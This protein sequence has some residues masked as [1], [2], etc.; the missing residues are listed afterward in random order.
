MRRLLTVILTTLAVF[1]A[2][3]DNSIAIE[4]GTVEP[5]KPYIVAIQT[6]LSDNPFINA[7]ASP[8]CTG[9]LLNSYIVVT[10]AHCIL[11]RAKA[12][13]ADDISVYV[14]DAGSER[15]I[16]G[17][18]SINYRNNHSV[19][20]VKILDTYNLT[21]SAS[22]QVQTDD[23]AFLTLNNPIKTE[24]PFEFAT[25]DAYKK[26]RESHSAINI[27]GFGY[28]G[29][30]GGVSMF[31]TK[32]HSAKAT[33][34]TIGTDGQIHNPFLNMEIANS[35]KSLICV[36]D[37]GGPVFTTKDGKLYLLGVNI[38]VPT[39]TEK[40]LCGFFNSLNNG[41]TSYF[42]NINP[43]L[44]IYKQVLSEVIANPIPSAQP[45][46]SPGYFALPKQNVETPTKTVLTKKTIT[47]LKG[48]TTK[49]IT[50]I[51]VKCPTGYKQK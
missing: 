22:R 26:I 2:A 6:S 35:A 13:I 10:A 17:G 49:K 18:W 43:Y 14:P 29:Q 1:I 46:N 25:D 12:T 27:Y 47:C 42:L 31:S 5:Y 8:T 38:G 37:S 48:K 15:N 9:T 11:N 24:T 20:K 33:I 16:Y 41:S 21:N 4:N 50:G 34:E 7:S 36:G 32:L 3:T 40:D 30:I 19:A 23:I 44:D 45:S 28:M 39:L 51:S